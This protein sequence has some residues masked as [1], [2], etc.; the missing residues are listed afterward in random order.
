MHI[1]TRQL[2][3]GTEV[4]VDLCI[5]GAG[6]AGLTI[7]RE[8][9][10]ANLKVA[11]LESGGLNADP[12]VQALSDGQV[13]GDSYAGPLRTRWRQAGGTA[14]NWNTHIG[15]EFGAKY[16]P[17]DRSDFV[18]RPWAPLSG[19]P[20][21]RDGLDPYHA[22][23]HQVC[24]LGPFTYMA[25]DWT[26]G[27]CAPLPFRSAI[28]STAVY[29]F[30]SGRLFTQ[31]YIAD[32]A[33]HA[34]L[35]LYLHANAVELETDR[36]AERVCAVRVRCLTGTEHRVRA[37]AFVLAAGGIENPRL[38]LLSGANA[39]GLGN[40]YDWVGRCFMEHPRDFSCALIP[41]EAALW[42]RAAFYAL[43][44]TPRGGVMGR[45]AIGEDALAS[46]RLL[47]ASVSFLVPDDIGRS[48]RCQALRSLGSRS[49]R[50]IRAEPL[51]LVINLEQAPRPENRIRLGGARD[52]LGLPMV[53]VDWRW[54]SD[55][56]R[57]LERLRGVLAAAFEG[58]GLGLLASTPDGRPDP[59][60]H[61]H[62]GTTRMHPDPRYGVVDENA[63]V[64]GVD[65]LYVA[66]S[67]VFPT[68]GY[69]NPTLTI[70]ALSLR[71]ADHLKAVL[72]GQAAAGVSGRLRHEMRTA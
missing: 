53:E 36:A 65:N 6:P 3:N 9:A 25:A 41:R 24:G 7:A 11:I 46:E 71:L 59:N 62:L 35:D 31:A 48:G 70:I 57:N 42:D 21:T 50:W 61:H 66:G 44:M 56:Q 37:R 26:D 32:L 12:A 39:G 2:P 18:P 38:L 54:R 55:D 49:I 30:G 13:T 51:H 1:D 67:S 19:W 63:R 69:A 17:L 23:A 5:M 4:E 27:R 20:L 47:N 34:P 15:P 72:A 28:L 14:N 45:L 29:Q 43:H 10:A 33:G 52:G 8:F 22:R 68:G 64:H 58:A 40:R 60:A 16:V